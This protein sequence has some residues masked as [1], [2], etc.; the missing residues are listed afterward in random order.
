MS[1][2]AVVVKRFPYFHARLSGTWTETDILELNLPEPCC[3]EDFL[4]L[5]R[6]LY[7]GG[8]PR[9]GSWTAKKVKCRTAKNVSMARRTPGEH[10]SDGDWGAWTGNA[11]HHE[12]VDSYDAVAKHA[13]RGWRARVQLRLYL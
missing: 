4:S 1:L 10:N 6:R 2:H 12:V 5:I 3:L 13:L 7:S 11:S 8:H 9:R